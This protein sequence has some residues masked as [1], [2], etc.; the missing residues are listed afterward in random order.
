MKSQQVEKL[1]SQ[2][3]PQEQ[4]VLAFT[5][6]MHGNK[7]QAELIVNSV[8]KRVYET[9]HADYLTRFHGITHLGSI[10]GIYYWKTLCQLALMTAKHGDSDE[11]AEI[12]EPYRDKLTAMDEAL[13]SICQKLK[14][15][16]ETIKHFA[17]LTGTQPK[18]GVDPDEQLIEHYKDLFSSVS[19]AND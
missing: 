13:H 12:S 17:E 16:P 10:Y 8:E 5:E 11:Y 3:T 1:Y 7:E 9:P 2:L 4:A 14:I 19:Y 18:F 6:V 15:E